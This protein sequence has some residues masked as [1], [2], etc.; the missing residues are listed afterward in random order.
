MYLRPSKA[1]PANI[2]T[3]LLL[4]LWS[5]AIIGKQFKRVREPC[6]AACILIWHANYFSPTQWNARETQIQ[7]E[8]EHWEEG[9]LVSHF[10]W[11]KYFLLVLTVL[12]KI[13]LKR[14]NNI[15]LELHCWGWKVCTNLVWWLSLAVH[16]AVIFRGCFVGNQLHGPPLL[17]GSSIGLWPR[18][19]LWRTGLS[20]IS[21]KGRS[22]TVQF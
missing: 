5:T 6:L 1:Y 3:R 7:D 8:P 11:V 10:E 4:T 14:W 18:T 12:E 22:L 17:G 16:V 19:S 9:L 2:A 21:P 15:F 13:T 20:P